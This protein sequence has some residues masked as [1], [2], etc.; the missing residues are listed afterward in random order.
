MENILLAIPQ[1]SN[2]SNRNQE[3]S[4]H[5]IAKST[6]IK[7]KW[8]R[9]L[10]TKGL[11]NLCPNQHVC[12]EHFPECKKTYENNVPTILGVQSAARSRKSPTVREFNREIEMVM[13]SSVDSPNKQI[14]SETNQIIKYVI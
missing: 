12:S 10:K 11:L 9:A 2:N 1:C 14:S 5:K 7:R 13:R 4:F 8:V 6:E 3:L